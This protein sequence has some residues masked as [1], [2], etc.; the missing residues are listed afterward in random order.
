M[1]TIEILHACGRSSSNLSDMVMS[2]PVLSLFIL[3]EGHIPS[4]LGR[5]V[6]LT[7]LDLSFNNLSGGIPSEVSQDHV[8]TIFIHTELFT[9]YWRNVG[10]AI[11]RCFT[12]TAQ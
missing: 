1:R 12:P 10:R 3:F 8:P 11:D 7:Q 9:G 4:T 5:L 2:L 6:N